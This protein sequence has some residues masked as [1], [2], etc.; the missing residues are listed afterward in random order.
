MDTSPRISTSLPGDLLELARIKLGLPQDVSPALLARA[1]VCAAAGVDVP[2]VRRGAKPGN[3][4]NRY[5]S[6]DTKASA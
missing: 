4:R 1:C 5:M 2:L 6:R 3:A